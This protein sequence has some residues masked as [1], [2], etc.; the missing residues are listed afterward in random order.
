VEILNRKLVF[1]LWKEAGNEIAVIQYTGVMVT[2]PNKP[3]AI[4]SQLDA[5]KGL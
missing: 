5:S 3:E 2:G 1:N 4:G